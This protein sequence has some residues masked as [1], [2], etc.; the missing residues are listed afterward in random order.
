[1]L[2]GGPLFFSGP[3]GRLAPRAWLEGRWGQGQDRAPRPSQWLSQLSRSERGSWQGLRQ[4][5]S[6]LLATP[7]QDG[8][9]GVKRKGGCPKAS[10]FFAFLG[11]QVQHVEVPRLGVESEL[12]LPAYTTATAV[13]DPS[14]ICD[15]CCSSRQG[16]TLNSLSE[17][18]GRTCVLMDTSQVPDH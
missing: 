15:L 18:R 11:L 7:P 8:V 13:R 16:W 1:M 12:Q 17:A 14:C 9:G 6:Q 5:R 2:P 3:W 4:Q 10:S